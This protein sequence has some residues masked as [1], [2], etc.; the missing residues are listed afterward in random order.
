MNAPR[1]LE[2]YVQTPL[3]CPVHGVRLF[4]LVLSK[5]ITF[6]QKGRQLTL[7]T[8]FYHV[9][10]LRLHSGFYAFVW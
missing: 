1:T 2:M 5:C 10:Y 8:V 6:W 9:V 7:F 3:P 4:V